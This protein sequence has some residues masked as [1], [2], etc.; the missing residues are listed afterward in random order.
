[1]LVTAAVAA[2]PI[3]TLLLTTG[4]VAKLIT[5][6]EDAGQG[7]LSRLGPAVLIPERFRRAAM[8]AGAL[9]EFALVAGQLAANLAVARWLTAVFFTMSTYVLWDLRRRRPDVGCGCFG[10]VSSAPVGL[11]SVARAA[12]LTAMA[13]VVAMADVG[14][15]DVLSGASWTAAAWAAGGLALLLSLSPEIEETFS[16]LRHRAPCEQRPM[17]A[18][19]ALSRLRAS[20]A[21]RAHAGEL[22]SDEPHD[23][24]RELCWRFFVFPGR[25]GTEVVFAVYL[26]GRRPAV[27]VAVVGQDGN[28]VEPLQESIAVSA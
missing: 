20:T 6:G 13:V 17:P 10:E 7:A 4:G 5:A 12:V 3:L 9:G 27:R 25:G 19:H 21:W 24:W 16:R 22:E 18:D 11:R 26:S 28:P 15:A 14:P 23:S 8:L 1:M 2:L